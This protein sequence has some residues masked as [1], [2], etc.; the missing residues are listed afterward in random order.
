MVCRGFE[1]VSNEENN[2]IRKLLISAAHFFQI[3]VK[4]R[5]LTARVR[6]EKHITMTMTNF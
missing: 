4:L 2:L 1:D 6:T 3:V 5:Q